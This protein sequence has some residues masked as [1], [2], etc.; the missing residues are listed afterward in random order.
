MLYIIIC[1]SMSIITLII[2]IRALTPNHLIN[3]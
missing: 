3:R 2:C 1:L